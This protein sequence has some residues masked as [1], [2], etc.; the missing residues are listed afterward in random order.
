MLDV[1]HELNLMAIKRTPTNLR[2]LHGNPGKKPLPKNEPKPESSIPA[3]PTGLSAAHRKEW[4]W[5]T[6][7]LDKVGLVTQIDKAALLVY[8]D[9][10]VELSEAL[11][12]I[13]KEGPIM[14][15]PVFAGNTGRVVGH[16][17]QKNPWVSYP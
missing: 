8:V 14:K 11:R 16:R 5:I 12:E 2:L 17:Y 3:C 6:S 4:K 13:V 7:E 15:V 1:D 9:A 10:Y